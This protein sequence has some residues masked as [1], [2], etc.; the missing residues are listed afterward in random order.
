MNIFIIFM[1]STYTLLIFI[2][3]ALEELLDKVVK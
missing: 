1:V 3:L 2:I